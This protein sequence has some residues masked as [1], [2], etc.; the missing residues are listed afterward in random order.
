MIGKSKEYALFREL[1]AFRSHLTG[2]ARSE[3]V[4]PVDRITRVL[5]E[6]IAEKSREF[7]REELNSEISK[8]KLFADDDPI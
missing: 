1:A 7:E 5:N 2:Q 3:G 4:E 6:L 8:L